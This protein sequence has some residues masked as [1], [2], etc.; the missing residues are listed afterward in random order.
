VADVKAVE[1]VK[2]LG[3]EARAGEWRLFAVEHETA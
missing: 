1:A 2:E 3:L